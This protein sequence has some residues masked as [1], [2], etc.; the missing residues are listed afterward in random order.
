MSMRTILLL[1]AA[2][3]FASVTHASDDSQVGGLRL[4]DAQ[5]A[6]MHAVSE[7]DTEN[8]KMMRRYVAPAEGAD[9]L[10][11]AYVH[12]GY[13]PL[14]AMMLTN[15]D[16]SEGLRLISPSIPQSA[17]LKSKIDYLRLQYSK[18]E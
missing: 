9:L 12:N 7:A 18:K 3:A 10:Y 14:H 5:T 1:S 16:V 6:E 17:D 11:D 15:W 2:M 8:A 13:L 4:R